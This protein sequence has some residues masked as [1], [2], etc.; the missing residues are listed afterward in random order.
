MWAVVVMPDWSDLPA[1]LPTAL[2]SCT[3]R[4]LKP[5]SRDL[6]PLPAS[7]PTGGLSCARA[8]A[9]PMLTAKKLATNGARIDFCMFTLPPSLSRHHRYCGVGK[10]QRFPFP[11]VQLADQVEGALVSLHRQRNRGQ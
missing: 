5:P 9:K 1:A 8:G 6:L 2:C 4:V 7:P 10:C 11:V 3:E